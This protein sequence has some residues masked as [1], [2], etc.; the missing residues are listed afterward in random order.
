VG[1]ALLIVVTGLRIAVGSLVELGLQ[2]AWAAGIVA[3]RL[4]CF[5]AC[6]SPQMRD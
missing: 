4:S 2:S 3:H 6:E 5:T 1:A